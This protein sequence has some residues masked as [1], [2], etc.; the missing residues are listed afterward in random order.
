MAVL[1]VQI[2]PTSKTAR[3]GFRIAARTAELFALTKLTGDVAYTLTSSRLKQIFDVQIFDAL[4]V[5]IAAATFTK[6]GGVVNLAA[7]GAGSQVFVVLTGN[8]K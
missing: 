8:S 5:K 1:A 7:L 6:A 2:S 3:K 4:G